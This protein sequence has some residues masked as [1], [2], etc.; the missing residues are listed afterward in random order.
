MRV[1]VLMGGQSSEREVSLKTGSAMVEAAE[2]LGYNVKPVFWNNSVDDIIADIRGIEVVLIALHGGAGE[3]GMIQSVLE[4]MNIPYTG[5]GPL[6]SGICMDKHISKTMVKAVGYQ[7]P[8]WTFY[9]QK[10]QALQAECT[11]PVVVKPTDQ[12][13]TVGLTIV[14]T[15]EEYSAAVELAFNYSDSIVVEQFITGRELTV[16]ILNNKAYPIVEI[17]PKHELY[18]YECK[19]QTGMSV[20][21]CPAV[22]PKTLTEEIETAAEGIFDVLK[23][24]QYGRVDFRLDAYDRFWFLEMNTLPG[25]TATSLVPKSVKATGMTF[26]K[27]ID[28]LIH[29][30]LKK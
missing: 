9:S 7:T 21:H 29:G 8:E 27:L 16:T 19:Y 3:N 23:C 5:S 28:T 1:G 13:S 17:V 10:N 20:Y 6:S 15:P 12:G 24:R 14:H 22:L 4:L 26:P 2:S 18:D 30:A 25:M 11:A